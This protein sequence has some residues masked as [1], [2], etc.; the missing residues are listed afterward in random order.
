MT[1]R[2]ESILEAVKG[3]VTSLTTTGTRVYRGRVY[4]LQSAELPGLLVYLGQDEIIQNLSTGKLD[5][6]LTVHIDAVV[7]SPT[8]QVDTTLNLIRSEVTVALQADYRQGLAYVMD[9][10]EL[11]A[12]E[13]ALTGEGDQPIGV[14]RMT[15][16][17]HYRR[18][19]AD[20]GA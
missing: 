1:H 11:G 17:I 5:S 2:A 20:P 9:T 3:K 7:K 10:L 13:P 16:Q 18:S 14:M 4:P 19:R 8:A 6:R 12:G 15:W